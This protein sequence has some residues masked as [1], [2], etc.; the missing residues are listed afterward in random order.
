MPRFVILEHDHPL[1]H[2]DL[3]LE[4]GS[5]LRTWR[6]AEPPS[7][8]EVMAESSFDHRL[9]YLDYEGPISGN[10]GVVRRWDHG[11]YRLEEEHED[12]LILVFEGERVRGRRTLEERGGSWVLSSVEASR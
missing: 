7:E 1:L 3:M 5:V 4:S 10:R 6:L 9:L 2:W 11:V 12:R 8:G